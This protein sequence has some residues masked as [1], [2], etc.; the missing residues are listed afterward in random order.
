MDFLCDIMRKKNKNSYKGILHLKRNIDYKDE[1]SHYY[2]NSVG[3]DYVKISQFPKYV[4]ELDLRNFLFRVEIFKKILNIHGSILELGVLFGG[5]LMSWAKLSSIYEPSNYSRKIVGFDT[6]S[7][8]PSI[9]SKD[10]ISKS[11]E[12]SRGMKN[13]KKQGNYVDSYD[14]LLK[15]ISLYDRDRYQN[16]SPKVEL[17]KGDVTKTLPKYLKENPHL[18]VSLLNLDLDIYSGTKEA[19]KLL[20][21]LMP[22][23]AI[24][25]F[26]ELNHPNWPGETIAVIEE[27]G[28]QNIRLKRFDFAPSPSYA[29]LE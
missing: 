3:T 11:I 26:D 2:Q 7:G 5:G 16:Q 20:L 15:S 10:K 8:F 4:T 9:S 13:P 24:I 21:P 18:I 28:I 12:K 27:L 14:D 23:G 29:I 25:C 22:K 19:L 17:V 6:F 1:I